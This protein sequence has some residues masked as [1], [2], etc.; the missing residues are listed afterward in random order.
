MCEKVFTKLFVYIKS[1]YE[2]NI[3]GR[4][5]MIESHMALI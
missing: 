4:Y 5:S 1:L 3:R 2:K